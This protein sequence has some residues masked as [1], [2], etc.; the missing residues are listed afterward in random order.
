[1]FRNDR[2][3]RQ[4]EQK[5]RMPELPFHINICRE[6][7]KDKWFDMDNEQKGAKMAFAGTRSLLFWCRQ[8]TEGYKKVN[9][10]NM[11]SSWRDG[12]AFCAI[13]HRYRPDLM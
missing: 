8:Q 12:L 6:L 5:L 1:M 13:I 11:S 7:T 10:F 4:V 2:R 3:T 9:V